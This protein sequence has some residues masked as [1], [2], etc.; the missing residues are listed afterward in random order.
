MFLFSFF[1]ALS[2]PLAYAIDARW[3]IR[4]NP[5]PGLLTF[6]ASRKIIVGFAV[7]ILVVTAITAL[8]GRLFCGFFCPLGSVID[9]IDS[10]I[11][12]NARNAQ[13]RPPLYLQK[14]KYTLLFAVALVA[15]T[16]TIFPLFLDPIS[17]ITRIATVFV[18]PLPAIGDNLIRPLLGSLGAGNRLPIPY[19][20]GTV[21][22]GLLFLV[23]LFGSYWDR[24][25]W[26]QYICPSGAF[27]G[28]LSR[29]AVFRRNISTTSCGGCKACVK[30]CPT[31]A[32]SEKNF[33]ATSTAE[34]IMCGKCVG[35][36]QGCSAFLFGA[37]PNHEAITLAPD[38]GRRQILAGVAAGTLL[39]PVLEANALTKRDNT[40]RLIRPPGAM[41]EN[42]FNAR[43]LACGQCIKVCPTN[44]LQPCSLDDGFS[45]L[46]TPKLSPRIGGCEE[47]CHACGNVCPTN[48]IRKLPY[49]EKRFAKMG[50][51]VIDKHRC[52]AWEQNKE[53]L[54]CD[55]VCPYHAIDPKFLQTSRGM[56]KVP[57]VDADLCMGCGMC[58]QKCPIFD[59]AA[60]VVYKFGENRRATGPY[61]SDAQKQMVTEKRKRADKIKADTGGES[62]GQSE[63]GP[64]ALP[65]AKTGSQTSQPENIPS[66]GFSF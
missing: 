13:R 36:K 40:G 60:I 56:F 61:L 7:V 35:I 39:L 17:I 19:F 14:L 52:L 20:Y 1:A 28:I 26:C 33:K 46:S 57:V 3:F 37:T 4:I 22:I 53:C 50:T 18:Y 21:G 45:R 15:L 12:K 31:R 41:P 25:F 58:E 63:Q 2:Y 38:M 43:C 54:V 8:Y 59:T 49:D 16:G 32:I 6:I 62:G 42:L 5:L 24:R 23:I 34:C 65:D 66:S 10:Q 51:A 9:F 47:K 48:A 55:E 64:A 44:A 27:F 29:F 11:F 30:I